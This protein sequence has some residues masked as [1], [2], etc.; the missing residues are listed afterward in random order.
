MRIISAVC[1]QSGSAKVL[2][3]EGGGG[4]NNDAAQAVLKAKGT[5]SRISAFGQRAT[6]IEA[7]SGTLRHFLHDVETG[8]R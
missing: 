4:L 3:S 7:S 6:T 2:Y 5:E 8:L 1:S